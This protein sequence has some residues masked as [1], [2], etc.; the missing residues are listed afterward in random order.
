MKGADMRNRFSISIRWITLVLTGILHLIA[1]VATATP[2][3]IQV[4]QSEPSTAEE[5]SIAIN[6]AN[7]SIL[8]AGAN[9]NYQF[10]STDGGTSWT[11]HFLSSSL[12]V[13]GDPCVVFDADGN[14]YYSHLAFPQGGSWLD[15][16]VVQKSTDGGMTWSDGVGVGHNPPKDQDKSIMTADRTGSPY[17]NNLYIAWTE[18]DTYGSSAPN[19]STRILF[20]RSDDQS[21]SWSTP[22]R[23]SDR[24]GNCLDTDE[25]V[26]GA[27]PAVGPEG[28]VYMAWSG[29]QQIFFDR[30]F[31]GGATF[32]NDFVVTSQPGGWAFEIPGVYRCNG[33]PITVCD[34]SSS[35]Y[36]GRIYVVFSDQRNG[37][38]DTDVFLCSS[39]DQGAT[40]SAPL[41]INDDVGATQQFFPWATVDPVTGTVAVVFYDRRN[42]TGAATEVTVAVSHDGGGSFSNTIV[43]DFP[44][45]PWDSV[46]FGD[47]IGIDSWAG[48]IYAI[49]MSMDEGELG[50]WMAK[51]A[52]P[53]AV[54]SGGRPLAETALVMK[55]TGTTTSRRTKISFTTFHD[56]QVRLSIYD[57]RG[58]LIQS[59]VSESR[60]AG[61]YTE[62]WDGTN[63]SGAKVASGMYVVHLQ[64]GQDVVTRKV[65]IVN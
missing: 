17:R 39:D 10:R 50:V 36:R 22:L 64:A 26:E 13:A 40:W 37:T 6:P 19:D 35:P 45:T 56:S 32:G 48:V 54:Q 27:T 59:L 38:D 46:F 29:H 24:G 20:S 3:A 7:P 61:Q 58:R 9:I 51:L 41:R 42:T 18:F 47:Y 12:G 63:R 23:I 31:D 30:S 57:V 65:V 62:M 16:I 15:R 52:F 5:L 14:L 53:S 8:A 55:A 43:S 25:T 60:I 11:E 4:H 28:Q 33:M 34:K 2:P 44:F 21:F 1:G 49:W